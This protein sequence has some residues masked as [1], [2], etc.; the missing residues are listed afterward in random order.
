MEKKIALV[1]GASRGIG[2]AIAEKLASQDMFV[3][4]TATTEQ[5]AEKISAYLGENGKGMVLNVTE[6]ESIDTLLA[7]IKEQFGDIDV[8]VNN[9]GITRDN[10]LMRMK[11]DEWFDIL[12]T[13]LTPIYR[14]SKAVLRPMMKKR[15]GRIINIGSVVG[16][17]GNPGQSNYCA[18]KAGVIGF[19]KSLAKEVA[20]RGITVNV[21]APGFIA[22]DMTDALTEDQKNAIL[23]QI[24][25]ARLGEAKDIANAV[26]F[27][28][29]EDA[30]YVT[31]TTM[32]VNGGLYLA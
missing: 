9:A 32:H 1:T 27:L 22:T 29:S 8:L 24:P 31:G 16:S 4:G 25:A 20:N 3:I 14:L 7:Q 28:A 10:L 26:A 19:S 13:N 18:A 11:D 30:G 17:M 23:S 5:G 2:R 6:P 21:V 15:F 12:Q